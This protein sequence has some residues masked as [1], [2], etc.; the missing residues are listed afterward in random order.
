MGCV[1]THA[2]RMCRSRDISCSS[3][4]S[5]TTFN[6]TQRTKPSQRQEIREQGSKMVYVYDRRLHS[7][8]KSQEKRRNRKLLSQRSGQ[9]LPRLNVLS[10]ASGSQWTFSKLRL[11]R[12][13]N[14]DAQKSCIK[15]FMTFHGLSTLNLSQSSILLNVQN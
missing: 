12:I 6:H 7:L 8:E 13:R 5:S 14:L 2:L 15:L 9:Q 10:G 1:C 3:R 4:N 11:K